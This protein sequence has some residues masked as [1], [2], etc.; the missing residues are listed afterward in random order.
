[1]VT[2][3]VADVA[4]VREEAYQKAVADARSRAER[5][6]KLTGVK[7]GRVLSAAEQEVTGDQSD[8]LNVY[9]ALNMTAENRGV[10]APSTAAV[11]I[12]VKLAVVFAINDLGSSATA[13]SSP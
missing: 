10:T 3:V 6:A 1:M 4:A 7:L 13:L 12:R 5:L 8:E 2:F 9:Q 11:P